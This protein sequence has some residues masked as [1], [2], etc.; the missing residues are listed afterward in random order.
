MD[1][2][3]GFA[4]MIFMALKMPHLTE[5]LLCDQLRDVS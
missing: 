1:T 5:H 4:W 2:E 3:V